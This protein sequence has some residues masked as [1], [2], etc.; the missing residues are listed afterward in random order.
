[1]KWIKTFES[2]NIPKTKKILQKIFKIK[3][4]IKY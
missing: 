3:N 4:W 2:Y 1:M